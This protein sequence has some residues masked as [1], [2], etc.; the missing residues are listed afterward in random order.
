MGSRIVC[1]YPND[2]DLYYTNIYI[3]INVFF[4]FKDIFTIASEGNLH[5]LHNLKVTKLIVNEFVKKLNVFSKNG[6]LKKN[7]CFYKIKI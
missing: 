4:F 6:K 7:N 1:M 5:M 2:I 3:Y